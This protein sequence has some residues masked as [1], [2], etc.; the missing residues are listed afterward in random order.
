MCRF[1]LICGLLAIAGLLTAARADEPPASRLVTI[2][3]AIAD[4]AGD[5]APAEVTPA[6]LREME[7]AGK[8]QSLTRIRLTTIENQQAQFQFGEKVPVVTGQERRG[9]R[10][11]SASAISL[12]NVGTIVEMLPRVEPDGSILLQMTLEKSRLIA[13]HPVLEAPTPLPPRTSTIS[14]K[15]T[16]RL[17]SD[18]PTIVAGQQS[19]DKDNGQTWIV[20]TAS[21]E[22]APERAAAAGPAHELKVFQLRFAAAADLAKVLSS[23]FEKEPVRIAAEVRTNSI[24]VQGPAENLAMVEALLLRL[25]EASPRK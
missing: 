5:A 12:E 6:S 16:V 11:E 19:E 23:V 14:S 9:P 24:L 13:L 8:L 1:M 20:L 22:A 18:E 17:K 2:E 7:K 4:L 25:D 3:V 10:G 21:A 15:A